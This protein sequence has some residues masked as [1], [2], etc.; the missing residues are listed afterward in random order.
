VFL[1]RPV[2]WALA[3]DGETG[4]ARALSM[5]DAELRNAMALLGTPSVADITRAHVI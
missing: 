5:I 3:A 1:G 2:L 4:V